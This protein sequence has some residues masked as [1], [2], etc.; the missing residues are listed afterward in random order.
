MGPGSQLA[1]VLERDDRMEGEI[2]IALTIL[3]KLEI[4]RT[5]QVFPDKEGKVHIQ[6][7]RNQNS[8]KLLSSNP[9]N[10]ATLKSTS[11][12]LLGLQKSGGKLFSNETFNTGLNNQSV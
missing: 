3:G 9:G 5:R 4:K 1:K 8:P 12:A 11:Q 7:N 10:V 2:I 6:M